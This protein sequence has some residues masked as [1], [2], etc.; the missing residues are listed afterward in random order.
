MCR[1]RTCDPYARKPIKAATPGK[2]NRAMENSGMELDG[3]G[4]PKTPNA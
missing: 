4:L 1:K 3:E 2:A